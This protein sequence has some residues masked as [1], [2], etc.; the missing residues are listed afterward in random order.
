MNLKHLAQ[1][2]G[3]SETT[4]SRALNGYPEVSEKT[5]V[6]VLAAA[7][8]VGYRPNPVARS[9][10]VGRTNVIGIVYP[11]LPADLGDPMFLNFVGGMSKALESKSMDLVIAPSSSVNELRSYE[12]IVKGKRV[13]GLVV[14]R[15]KIRDERISFLAKHGWPF[16]AHGRTSSTEPYAWFD[17]D[18]EAG[19]RTAM[20][21]LLALGHQ[22]IGFISAPLEMTC[23]AQRLESFKKCLQSSGLQIDPRYLLADAL[24]RRSG[25]QAMQQLLHCS[26]RPTAV[27]VDNH[28]AGVGAMR[29]LMDA[30]IDIGREI[31][32]V[33]WGNLAD[34][35]LNYQ[36]TTIEQPEQKQAGAKVI[37]MLL[38]LLDGTPPSELQVMWQPVLVPGNTIG[39]C[40]R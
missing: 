10:A 6:R 24:D 15:T 16:I 30:E 2:L 25:Y 7:Q 12:H 32:I 34:S 5:R 14:S 4:V 18:N 36:V 21:E 3:I 26:P 9:L 31:S 11:L 38:S 40:P 13:D 29:A 27:I 22:R 28:L 8:A 37:E 35:L 17:Y 19:I 23:A 1:T 39:R 20:E 33:I